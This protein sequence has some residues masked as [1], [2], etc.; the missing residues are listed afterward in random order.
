MFS[1]KVGRRCAMGF[2]LLLGRNENQ[3]GD[4]CGLPET[5]GTTRNVCGVPEKT[6]RVALM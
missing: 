5:S 6:K 3:N 2:S 1:L 4:L